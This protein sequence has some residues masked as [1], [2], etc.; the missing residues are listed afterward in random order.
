VRGLARLGECWI[1]GSELELHA[2]RRLEAVGQ[3]DFVLVGR[4]GDR[5]FT[6]NAFGIA[7]RKLGEVLGELSL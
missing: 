5:R 1:I 4:G 6:R 3:L 7:G 2:F